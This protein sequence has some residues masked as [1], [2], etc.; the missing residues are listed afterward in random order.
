MRLSDLDIP[1]SQLIYLVENYVYNARNKTLFYK[2]LEGYT[3]EEIAE[4]YNL[5]TQ[6]TKE[7]VQECINKISKHI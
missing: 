3:Y 4:M 1:K 7:I 5:S 2:K 6:R